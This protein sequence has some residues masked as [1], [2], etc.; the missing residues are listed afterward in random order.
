[1]INLQADGSGLYSVQGLWTQARERL[2]VTTLIFA[3]HS[4]AILQGE[5][6]NVGV[7]NPGRS[8]MDML[9]LD[10]PRIDWIHLANGFG[11]TGGRA[12]TMEELCDLF[13]ASLK[14]PGPF[15]IEVQ[16]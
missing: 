4:Y 13:V 12:D 5:M 10:R 14:E 8:A 11:V 1:M 9:S 7:Q 2:D 6:T 3:N 15:V 16:V